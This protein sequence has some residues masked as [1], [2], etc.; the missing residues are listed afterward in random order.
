VLVRILVT[1]DEATSDKVIRAT[2]RQ[3]SV[4]DASLRATDEVQRKI[5]AH[6]ASAGWY[7]DRRK[8][9]YRNIGKSPDRIISIPLLGQ[10]V[11]G[12]A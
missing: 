2:N 9:Y 5:E 6:F 1:S 7:Y 12:V 3:T 11:M 10:A 4:P 8:N